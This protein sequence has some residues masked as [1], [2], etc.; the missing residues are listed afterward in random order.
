MHSE[1]KT[2]TPLLLAAAVVLVIGNTIGIL[3]LTSKLSRMEGHLAAVKLDQANRQKD[4]SL[5]AVASSS[6]VNPTRAGDSPSDSQYLNNGLAISRIDEIKQQ[7][8]KVSPQELARSMDQLLYSQP[9]NPAQ[10]AQQQQW[11]QDA[12]TAMSSKNNVPKAGSVGSTCQGKRCVVTATFSNDI[13]AE[14]WAMEYI[15]A[16]G[17]RLL[18]NSR[19]VMLPAPDSTNVTLQLYLY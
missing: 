6:N 19:T 8:A 10:E 17:G 9:T 5:A 11:L 12:A 14:R 4:D 7:A 1:Q 16:T 15:L 13:A 3:W 2:T 18:S